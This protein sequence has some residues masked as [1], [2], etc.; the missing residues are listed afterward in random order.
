M[1][2][3]DFERQT[4]DLARALQD[5]IDHWDDPDRVA[6]R[7]EY[8]AEKARWQSEVFERSYL[9]TGQRKPSDALDVSI[10]KMAM[11]FSG[12]IEDAAAAGELE[13]M[14]QPLPVVKSGRDVALE[15][16]PS[17][18]GKLSLDLVVSRDTPRESARQPLVR[19]SR[20]Q[21]LALLRAA[22]VGEYIVVLT[23]KL[24]AQLP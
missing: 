20:A 22:Q 4:E 7:E 15:L 10:R 8:E 16:V 14:R 3:D 13:R 21:V 9:G 18:D 5:A 1:T 24:E 11:F 2:K 17:T 19:G 12:E 6:E 23:R